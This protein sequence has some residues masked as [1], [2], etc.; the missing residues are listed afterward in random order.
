MQRALPPEYEMFLWRDLTDA[1]RTAMLE[2]QAREPWYT[3]ALD[4]FQPPP[5]D[6]LSSLGL[7]K[8]GRVVGWMITHHLPPNLV[9]FTSLFVRS[10]D[11]G[12]G[13]ALLCSSIQ[14][15]VESGHV[16]GIFGV[17]QQNTTMLGILSKHLRPFL[18][19]YREIAYFAKDL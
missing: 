7:K 15:A 3:S 10:E 5:F 4:P 19:E 14:R 8:N 2:E 1:D 9:R 18:D 11:R 13:L 16:H 6:P 17:N 12:T